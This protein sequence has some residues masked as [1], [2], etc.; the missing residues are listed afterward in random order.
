MTIQKCIFVSVMIQNDVFFIK[1]TYYSAFHVGI[2][3][4][5]DRRTQEN[6]ITGE[7]FYR[8]IV[9]NSIELVSI[10]MFVG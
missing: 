4:I 3:V 2:I 6:N 10:F 9:V 8:T 5:S 7:I 1:T